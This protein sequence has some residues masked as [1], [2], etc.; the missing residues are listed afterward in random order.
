[1]VYNESGN[2]IILFESG[3]FEF[4]T[5]DRRSTNSAKIRELEN[6]IKSDVDELVKITKNINDENIDFGKNRTAMKKASKFIDTIGKIL[7]F[8][9][10][11]GWFISIP[12]IQISGILKSIITGACSICTIVIGCI[13]CSKS[14]DID[15]KILS[16]YEKDINKA[17]ELLNKIDKM[18]LNDELKDQVKNAINKINDTVEEINQAKNLVKNSDKEA[19]KISQQYKLEQKYKNAG[20]DVVCAGVVLK[21]Y[22]DDKYTYIESVVYGCGTISGS[23]GLRRFEI[24]LSK[25]DLEVIGYKFI[26][27]NEWEDY[28]D[29]DYGY[30]YIIIKCE[31]TDNIPRKGCIFIQYC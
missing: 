9:G 25:D 5:N 3:K 20:E 29:F 7:G 17:L 27:E 28:L 30:K 23:L 10:F 1:M 18:K 15:E 13:M 16:S 6:V 4:S 31:K 14:S 22:N 11:A 12:M 2:I 26:Y 21:S 24:N 19:E 8:G